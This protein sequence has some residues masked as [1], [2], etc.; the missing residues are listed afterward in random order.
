LFANIVLFCFV[1]FCFV[2]FCFAFVFVFAFA[3][4]LFCFVLFGWQRGG[5]VG[6]GIAGTQGRDTGGTGTGIETQ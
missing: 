6:A 5:S 3:L 1:V 4:F 2:L